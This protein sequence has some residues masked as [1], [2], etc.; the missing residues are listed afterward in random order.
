MTDFNPEQ[1][2]EPPQII[3]KPA[4]VT[5]FG[6]LNIVFGCYHLFSSSL[7]S[8]K[9]I[10]TAWNYPQTAASQLIIII[11]LQ[12][13]NACLWIWLI[14]VGIGLLM[15]KKWSRQ[16]AVYYSW[17]QIILFAAVWSYNITVA[18]IYM[19]EKTG[20]FIVSMLK[21]ADALIYPILLL[22]FM[23]TQKV[24]QAFAALGGGE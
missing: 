5:V 15:M 10:M 8:Y 22:I 18:R 12:A 24:K 17:V 19:P 21:M 1:S 9:V 2:Q 16:Q 7:V 3:G 14:V 20:L 13:I 23:Q 6:V 11:S 4:A